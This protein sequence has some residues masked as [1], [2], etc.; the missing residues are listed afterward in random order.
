MDAQTIPLNITS[1][2]HLGQLYM[3][4]LDN[5]GLFVPTRA[6]YQLGDALVLELRLPDSLDTQRVQGEVVWLT[7]PGAQGNRPAGIGIRFA[8]PGLP[9]QHEIERLLAGRLGSDGLTATL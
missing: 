9:V 4:F 5:G 7:P 3:P 6:S 2:E 8:E 1:R